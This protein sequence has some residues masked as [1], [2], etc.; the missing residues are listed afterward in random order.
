MKVSLSF[1]A[2]V[3]LI[4][5]ASSMY[6][7]NEVDAMRFS[8]TAPMGTA[9]ALGAGGAFSAVGADFSAASLNP[10]G[11]ALYR[12]S[13]LMF[14]PALR[15]STNNSTYLSES[16]ADAASKFGFTNFGYVYSG[17][18]SKW[19]RAAQRQEFAEK[20]LKSYSFS[21]GFNQ[22]MNYKRNTSISA[23][24]RENSITDYYAQQSQGISSTNIGNLTSLPGLA[25]NAYATDTSGTDG[26]YVGAAQGG[27]VEQAINIGE[28]GH[29]ND[30]TI[31]F[32]GNIS[33]RLYLGGAVGIQSLR[34]DYALNFRERDILDVHNTW[35]NDSIPFDALSMDDGFNTR[36]SGINLR[37]GAIFRPLDFLRVG[38]SFT[39]PTWYNLTDNYTTDVEGYIDGD[40]TVYESINPLQG[41]YSYNFRTPYKV[42]A[43]A[44]LLIKKLAFVSADFEYTDYTSAKFSSSAS[45]G[46]AYY[47]DFATENGNIQQFF[48]GTYNL[49]LGGEMRLGIARIRA[50]YAS[51]GAIL[52]KEYLNYVD[53]AT[54]ATEILPSNRHLFTGGLGI[55]LES[56]YIDFAYVREM[57]ADRRLLYTLNDPAEFS[58][59]LINKNNASNLY[60]T[61]GFTF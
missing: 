58:P 38:L 2:I 20:G 17:K 12:R 11:L 36:G 26:N 19:N 40:A 35:A 53:Y 46:S 45:P 34:Y 22:S 60:M 5:G 4:F 42:T 23:F 43:G 13:D 15:L 61:I 37:V 30:W 21:F 27:N 6:A 57:R 1:T 32:A 7:Q 33:D 25:W 52:K 49:R 8:L 44:M 51:Y 16:S 39:S 28:T 50:G 14:T 41:V 10:A 54:Q 59:E 18:V 48:S 47:Y 56:F 55:K 29:Q 24:N 31:G 3:L 9:R